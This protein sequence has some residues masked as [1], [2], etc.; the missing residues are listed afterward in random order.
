[1]ISVQRAWVCAGLLFLAP[2]AD[3]FGQAKLLR[4]IRADLL[5]WRQASERA[6]LVEKYGGND[7]S[8][9]AVAS[10]VRW[11]ALH[12]RPDGS[13]SFDHRHG[14]SKKDQGTSGEA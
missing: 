3:V 10:G 5:P 7:A 11:L 12:Q 6:K 4:P 9:E 8:E 14:P 2:G 1:M 13:W